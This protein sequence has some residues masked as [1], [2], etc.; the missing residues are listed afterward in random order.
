M[1]INVASVTNEWIKM[2]FHIFCSSF[3]LIFCSFF[4]LFL[5]LLLFLRD[6]LDDYLFTA[7]ITVF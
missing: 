1:N 4:P 2:F 5:G 3:L 6:S 7:T